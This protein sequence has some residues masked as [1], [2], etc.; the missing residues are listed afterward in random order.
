MEAA[1]RELA[2][3]RPGAGRPVQSI[4]VTVDIP[5]GSSDVELDLDVSYV[6][7]NASWTSTYD[8]RLEASTLALTWYGLVTQHTGEDWP[9]CDLRLSTARPSGAASVPSWTHGSSTGSA[10][11]S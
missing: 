7:L 11:S 4:T 3:R 5:A 10:R 2:A 1:A 8:L 9:E 6:A